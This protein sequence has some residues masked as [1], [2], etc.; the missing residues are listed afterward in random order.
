MLTSVGVVIVEGR[1]GNPEKIKKKGKIGTGE[2]KREE[3]RK[4]GEWKMGSYGEVG[5]TGLG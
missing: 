3:I 1:I 4:M 5:V 2:N